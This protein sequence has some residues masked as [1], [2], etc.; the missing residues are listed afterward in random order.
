[1]I[2]PLIDFRNPEKGRWYSLEAGTDI[3]GQK[4]LVRRWGSVHS[5]RGSQSTV[6]ILPNMNALKILRAELRR[7]ARRGY[8]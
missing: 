8:S 1:M 3:F 2:E 4:V 5:R 6:P 7:R